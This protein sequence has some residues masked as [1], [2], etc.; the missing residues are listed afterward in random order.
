LQ[1]L[2]DGLNYEYLRSNEAN[3]LNQQTVI[4]NDKGIEDLIKEL[5][6]L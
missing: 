1:K 2:E 3:S 5:N 6:D 4:E